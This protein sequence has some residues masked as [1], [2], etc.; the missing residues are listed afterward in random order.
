MTAISI[1][2]LKNSLIFRRLHGVGI[3]Q[4]Y[5]SLA[6]NPKGDESG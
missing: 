3:Q 1:E 2:R 4:I 5:P 6:H